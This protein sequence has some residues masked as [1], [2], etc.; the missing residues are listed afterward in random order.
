MKKKL[1]LT[2][3]AIVCVCFAAF[4][5]ATKMVKTRV[6]DGDGCNGCK[7]TSESIKCGKCNSPMESHYLERKSTPNGGEKQKFRYV[8]TSCSHSS[9]Y[10]IEWK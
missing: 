6:S 1:F 3:L 10:W 4:A 5:I 9:I 7:I 2:V 8:C